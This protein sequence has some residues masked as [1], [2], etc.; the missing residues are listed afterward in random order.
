MLVRRLEISRGE[1]SHNS[2][3]GLVQI[4]YCRVLS[5]PLRSICVYQW[6]LCPTIL[7]YEHPVRVSMDISY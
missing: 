7:D 1:S 3:T 6:L 5:S 2:K 4:V